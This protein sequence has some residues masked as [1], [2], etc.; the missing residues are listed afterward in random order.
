MLSGY[1]IYYKEG[2]TPQTGLISSQDYSTIVLRNTSGNLSH[3][4]NGVTAGNSYL[5]HVR[6]FSEQ[7][8][9]IK[10][11]GDVNR[12]VLVETNTMRTVV[13]TDINGNPI[14]ILDYTSTSIS[15]ISTVLPSVQAFA[16]ATGITRV[17]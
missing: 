11:L 13:N 12:E 4:I 10:L 16:N 2:S 17:M 14:N 7:S 15:S 6:A 8:N 3:T 5:I 1:K 9:N